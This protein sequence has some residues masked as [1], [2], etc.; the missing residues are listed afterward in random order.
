MRMLFLKKHAIYVIVLIFIWITS[1]ISN[2]LDSLSLGPSYKGNVDSK[3]TAANPSKNPYLPGIETLS[4][5]SLFSTGVIL[6]GI[7]TT[8]PFYRFLILSSIK[9]WYGI[10]D[11]EPEKG[12]NAEVLSTFLSSSLNIEL[13]YIIL[14]GITKFS[15]ERE[16]DR[17]QDSNK[18][19]SKE[20]LYDI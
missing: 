18:E 15:S 6:M 3:K 4:R 16:E 7:R 20:E 12:I 13:V 1:L 19:S 10:I 5:A 2:Y 8:D 9:E 11:E 17:N 14:A